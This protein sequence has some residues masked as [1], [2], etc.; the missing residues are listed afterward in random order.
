MDAEGKIRTHIGTHY[1]SCIDSRKY[2]ITVRPL[3]N[4]INYKTTWKIFGYRD[5]VKIDAPVWK[6]Q[7]ETN[8]AAY[9]RDGKKHTG[10]D[11]IESSSTKKKQKDRRVTYVRSV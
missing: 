10:T 9:P 6:N 7:C 11:T 3:A 2:T 4:H 1:L 5:M 8:L